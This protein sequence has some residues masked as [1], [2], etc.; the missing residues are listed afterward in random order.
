MKY[1]IFSISIFFM[2]VCVYGQIPCQNNADNYLFCELHGDE[3]S[4]SQ[5][6]DVTNRTASHNVSDNISQNSRQNINNRKSIKNNLISKSSS[7]SS[8]N[9]IIFQDSLTKPSGQW[10]VHG[11]TFSSMG[12]TSN[13]A[14]DYIHYTLPKGLTHATV[15]FEARGFV[16]GG[17]SRR[18]FWQIFEKPD[19]TRDNSQ[20]FIMI[21]FYAAQK[22]S[23]VPGEIRF[24]MDGPVFHKKQKN[25][26]LQWDPEKFYKIAVS[27]NGSVATW[28][29]DGEVIGTINYSGH[30]VQLRHM[31]LNGGRIYENFPGLDHITV[32]NL[33]VRTD[34][35]SFKTKIGSHNDDHLGSFSLQCNYPNP[36]NPSTMI[37]YHAQNPG[38]VSIEIFNT[39]GQNVKSLL[40]VFQTV[41]RH[42]IAW[43]GP[44]FSFDC[45]LK[46][47]IVPLFVAYKSWC[48][49]NQQIL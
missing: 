27:W 44:G 1:L 47:V 26:A 7:D 25:K 9:I 39:N 28:S 5:T 19:N 15:E 8:K 42:T 41:G 38:Y 48:T 16:F 45:E 33:V 13:N 29:R 49:Q 20:N 46:I 24:R 11:G 40:N 34:Q 21:R 32:R 17:A 31:Y 22:D 14:N 18:H 36:V 30:N 23:H 10:E 12:W 37:E 4:Q 6:N 35:E 43:N 2:Q 3:Y